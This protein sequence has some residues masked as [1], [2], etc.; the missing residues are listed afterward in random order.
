[1][2]AI[3]IE[4]TQ[5]DIEHI[6]GMC[7]CVHI[8]YTEEDAINLLQTDHDYLG[9][10]L[11]WGANDTE[12]REMLYNHLAKRFANLKW[13]AYGDSSAYKAEFAQ[14][15]TQGAVEQ[16]YMSPENVKDFIDY[17]KSGR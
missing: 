15:F 7:F 12:V 4:I 13:P 16:G 10:L 11:Y 14:K 17:F 9:K 6:L 2:P 8:N 3:T 1:M 5:S